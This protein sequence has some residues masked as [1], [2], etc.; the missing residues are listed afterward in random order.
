MF[1]IESLATGTPVVSTDIGSTEEIL[2]D[3]GV[4]VEPDVDRL[5]E[6]VHSAMKDHSS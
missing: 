3:S 1:E 4:T 5:G 6:A 2:G